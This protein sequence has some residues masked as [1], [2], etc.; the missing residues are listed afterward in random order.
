MT[1]NNI[2]ENDIRR[3]NSIGYEGCSMKGLVCS[4]SLRQP[5]P[6]VSESELIPQL[7]RLSFLALQS[8]HRTRSHP[9]QK[10]ALGS[11]AF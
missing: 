3:R 8:T 9:L 2:I 4:R 10:P 6:C 5:T 7:R 1:F 11:D